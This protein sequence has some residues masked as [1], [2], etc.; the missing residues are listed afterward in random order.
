[1]VE[2]LP[3]TIRDRN[4]TLGG[5]EKEDS[6]FIKGHQLYYNFI[7]PH[8]ALDGKTPSEMAGI[9]IGGKEKR[10]NLMFKAIQYQRT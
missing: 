3:G 8:M 2:R 9:T 1:M 4:K 10:L 5:L 7:K 6:I